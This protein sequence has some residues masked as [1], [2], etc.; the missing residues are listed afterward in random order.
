VRIRFLRF[1]VCH[2]TPQQIGVEP[3]AQCYRSNRNAWL[4]ACPDCLDLERSAMP[5]A[6]HRLDFPVLFHGVHVSTSLGGHDA[7]STA[8]ITSRWMA[9]HLRISVIFGPLDEVGYLPYSNR[10]ADPL[11][12]PISRRYEQIV[13]N[14]PFVE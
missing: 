7:L 1:M 4:H 11:F 12:E 14:Q 8:R 10:H 6:P 2:P 13:T 9:T 3:V 5:P